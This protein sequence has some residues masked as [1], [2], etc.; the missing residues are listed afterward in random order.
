MKPLTP[1]SFDMDAHIQVDMS[2]R[3]FLYCSQTL[4]SSTPPSRRVRSGLTA[5]CDLFQCSKAHAFK[6]A[7][8]DWFK[9]ALLPVVGRRILFDEVIAL[10]L[11]HSKKPAA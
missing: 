9:P 6:I 7:H 1:L 4:D 10:E 3:E 5:I 11:A 8:S 2:M